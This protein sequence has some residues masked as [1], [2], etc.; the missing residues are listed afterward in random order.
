MMWYMDSLLFVFTVFS[1]VQV[2]EGMVEGRANKVVGMTPI[3]LMMTVYMISRY[4]YYFV[5]ESD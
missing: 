4:Y 2:I 1:W 3:A 5:D